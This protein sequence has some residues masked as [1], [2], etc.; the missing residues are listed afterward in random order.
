MAKKIAM[1]SGKGGSGKT[2]ISL[3]FS[4]TLSDSNL[5][6]LLIDCD[7]STH[8]ATFFMKHKIE[9]IKAEKKSLLAVDD[10][11]TEKNMLPY[12]FLSNDTAELDLEKL[13]NVENS[14]WFLPS[15]VSITNEVPNKSN[16][17]FQT[18]SVF[19]KEELESYFDIIIFDC[20]AGYS[21]FTRSILR[22]SDISLLVTE[23]DSVSAAANKA[24]CF[25]VGTELESVRSFQLFSKLTIEEEVAYSK[26]T[27]SAFFANLVPVLYDIECRR[28]F[29]K[30]LI[31]SATSVNVSFEN[32]IIEN[33]LILFPEYQNEILKHKDKIFLKHRN[34]L[35][36]KIKFLEAEQKKE[37]YSKVF[38]NIITVF[39][40][41]YFA[42]LLGFKFVDNIE[43]EFLNLLIIA[44]TILVLLFVFFVSIDSKKGKISQRQKDINKLKK[45]LYN[46]S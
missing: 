26:I 41:A 3:A 15:D 10:I 2:S 12:G 33:L 43:T 42:F 24:L 45:Q 19:V 11:L 18:F 22:N 36:K 6:V 46:I 16:L 38:R 25:Q 34:D 29:M 28:T 27:T 20:Q 37:R 32:R 39:S 31:P 21:D 23:P 5:K 35:R 44:A 17:F 8:G 1:L 30:L 13:I 7:M 14:F 9:R 40:L 4:K